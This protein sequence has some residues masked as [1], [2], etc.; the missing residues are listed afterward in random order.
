MSQFEFVEQSRATDWTHT[1]HVHFNRLER[2][3]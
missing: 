3:R 2:V 1:P